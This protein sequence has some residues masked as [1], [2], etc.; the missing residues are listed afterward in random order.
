M[1][2]R[3]NRPAT[4]PAVRPATR[5]TTGLAAAS[6]AAMAL[7]GCGAGAALVGVTDA[8]VENTADAPLSAQAAEAIAGRVLADAARARTAT[9]A[10]ARQLRARALAGAALTISSADSRL[11]RAGATA[12]EPVTRPADPRVLAVSRGNAW[13]RVILVQSTRE[14]G[15]AVLNLLVSARASAPFKLA[16]SAPMQPG[17][18]IASLHALDQGSPL[19]ADGTG[20][21][22]APADLLQEYA[23]S[24]AHPGP[25]PAPH[26]EQ[27]DRF[28]TAVRA[29]AAAQGKAVA[30]LAAF[31]QTHTPRP[32]DTVVIG[33]RDGGAVVFGLL[34][35][36]D[37]VALKPTGK[38]LTP[39]P[40]LQKL[41][42]RK[43]LAK[44][45]ELRTYETVVFTVPAAGRARLV[46]VDETLV[47]AEGE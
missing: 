17:S 38:S 10:T 32:R 28:T 33:L 47:A 21:A 36:V 22:I 39:P 31:T 1:T 15:A 46:A 35:R 30:R 43:T 18:S 14:D 19:K 12:T 11:A 4:R 8:P 45:A 26:V 40:D 42:G 27:G 6:L 7:S 2:R 16:A 3:P 25:R 9:G 44:R 41:L 37:T 13:P 23:A 20:L 5:L 24:L 29:G 34:E